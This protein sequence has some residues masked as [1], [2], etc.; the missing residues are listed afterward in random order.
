MTK[1]RDRTKAP[2]FEDIDE[3]LFSMLFLLRFGDIECTAEVILLLYQAYKVIL[4]LSVTPVGCER[5]FSKLRY[6]KNR[7]RNQLS[8]DRLDSLFLMCVE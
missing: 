3:K 8:G 4:T 1:M 2:T 6:V 5:T 7:V